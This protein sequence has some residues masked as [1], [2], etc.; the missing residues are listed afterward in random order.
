MESGGLRVLDLESPEGFLGKSFEKIPASLDT[1]LSIIFTAMDIGIAT[2][3][4]T[5]VIR[6]FITFSK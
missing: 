1:P 3:Y 2:A 5:K 4:D 6:P